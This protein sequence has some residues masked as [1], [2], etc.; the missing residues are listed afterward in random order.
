MSREEAVNL[1]KKR[2]V[3]LKDNIRVSSHGQIYKNK[4]KNIFIDFRLNITNSH[5]LN[6]FNSSKSVTLS[7][8][9]TIKEIKNIKKTD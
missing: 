2:L 1:C 9:L 6:Q 4:N 7:P 3:I 8:E 5:S